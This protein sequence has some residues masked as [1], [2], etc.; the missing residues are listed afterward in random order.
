MA[1]RG[2]ALVRRIFKGSH[3]GAHLWT[4]IEP[5]PPRGAPDN[6]EIWPFKRLV[7]ASTAVPA[8]AAE[9]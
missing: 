3:G 5:T 8:A 4:L 9:Q 1:E 7:P 6:S 2:E